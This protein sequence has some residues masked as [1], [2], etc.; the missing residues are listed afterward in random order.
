MTQPNWNRWWLVWLRAAFKGAGLI[1][2]ETARCLACGGEDDYDL[3]GFVVGLQKKPDYRWFQGQGRRYP[4]GPCFPAASIPMATP[5]VLCLADYTGEEVLPEIGWPE[6]KDVLLEPTLYLC[7]ACPASLIKRRSGQ[8]HRPYHRRRFYRK[9]SP[10]VCGWIW[11]QKSMRQ[12]ACAANFKALE[13][14][15]DIGH[16]E[17]FE[18]FNMG[19]GL[20]L[21]VIQRMWTV[22]RPC[23]TNQFTKSVG[24]WRRRKMPVWW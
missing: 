23:L 1:G 21:A 14:Y 15:G 24:L 16:E 12:G 18:I 8:W 10:H 13:K 7:A 4:S 11:P 20:M 17:M 2:G 9:C 6:L 19:I 22:S 3:A 5:L